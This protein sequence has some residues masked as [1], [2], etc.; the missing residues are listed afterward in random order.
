ML[1]LVTQLALIMVIGHLDAKPEPRLRV[2]TR[3]TVFL[4][5]LLNVLIVSSIFMNNKEPYYCILL[6]KVSLV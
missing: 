2:E 6:Y 1:K 4:V 3:K 5:R